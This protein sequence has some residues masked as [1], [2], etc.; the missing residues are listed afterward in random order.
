M[1]APNSRATLIEYSLR[2]LGAPVIEINVDPDQ[3]EDRLDEALLYYQE[4]HSD[5]T[6]RTYL[7][8]QVTAADITNGYIP[9]NDNVQIV[10]KLFAIKGENGSRNFFDIKYQLHLNDIASMQTFIGDLAYY[11]QMMQYISLLDMKLNGSPQVQFSREQRRLYIHGDLK[12]GDILEGDYIVAEIYEIIDPNT[13][14]SIYNDM[15]LKKYIT[16][17]IKEQWGMNLLK[18]EGMQ[19]PGGVMLNGRQLYEDAQ[20]ELERLREDIRL[21]HEMPPDFFVG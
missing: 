12:D 20:T 14:T 11:E 16:A 15:W 10:S 4:Y 21:E 8:H 5:A 9:L 7:Q 6:L 13:F 17:L 3:L 19:L 2:R 1:A 18:F